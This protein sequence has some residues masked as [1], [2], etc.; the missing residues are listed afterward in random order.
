VVTQQFLKY[1]RK[2]L[3]EY[4]SKIKAIEKK[5]KSSKMEVDSNMTSDQNF[6]LTHLPIMDFSF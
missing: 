3:K 1:E 6:L 4:R 2:L 5:Q